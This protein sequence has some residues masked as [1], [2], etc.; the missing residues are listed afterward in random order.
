MEKIFPREVMGDLSPYP[1]VVKVT[2]VNRRLGPTIFL[3]SFLEVNGNARHVLHHVLDSRFFSNMAL[4][5]KSSTMF[6][7]LVSCHVGDYSNIC[8]A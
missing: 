8:Q 2:V 1:T 5:A 6:H 3:P 4:L 7:T